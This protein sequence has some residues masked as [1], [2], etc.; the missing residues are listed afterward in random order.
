MTVPTPAY[1]HSSS[2][3]RAVCS[4]ETAWLEEVR[5]KA[6]T[7]RFGQVT[8]TIHDGRVV[9]LEVNEKTRFE[10]LSGARVPGR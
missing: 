3:A 4:G 9:Q 10:T 6:A 8:I 2:A 5:R 7:L 1:T